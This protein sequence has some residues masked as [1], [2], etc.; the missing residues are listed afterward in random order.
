MPTV[1]QTV[2]VY[3]F[4]VCAHA[5]P[6]Q[7]SRAL[8]ILSARLQGPLAAEG[9]HQQVPLRRTAAVEASGPGSGHTRVHGVR[10][11]VP[12]ALP[13]DDA[14]GGPFGA[15]GLCVRPVSQSVQAAEQFEDPPAAAHGREDARVP[16]LPAQVLPPE[17]P[18]RPP[19][20]AQCPAHP[21]VSGVRADVLVPQRVERAHERAHA[22]EELQVRRVREGVPEGVGAQQAQVDAPEGA[23]SVRRLRSGVCA[24]G[25]LVCAH[26]AAPEG[27]CGG[28]RGRV[29]GGGVGRK[30]GD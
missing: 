2:Q 28:G 6:W 18:A 19:E 7:S 23:V 17:A 20:A 25:P 5:G 29:G 26:E 11:A 3:V 22:G 27:V 24:D 16:R 21:R 10:E 30:F 14:H 13:A 15:Q 4:G 9:T 8:R 12:A 1:R